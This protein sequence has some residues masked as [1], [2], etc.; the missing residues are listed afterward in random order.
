MSTER[1]T[2]GQQTF[3]LIRAPLPSLERMARDADP[4]TSHESAAVVA[5]ALGK[6]QA[7]VLAA[8]RDR[9]RMTARACESLPEFTGYGFSTVRRRITEL[10]RAGWLVAVG[11]DKSMKSPATIYAA[12]ERSGS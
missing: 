7:E 6:I 12:A 4:A 10:H 5:P 9:G 8:F 11:V 3:A 1:R 2:S